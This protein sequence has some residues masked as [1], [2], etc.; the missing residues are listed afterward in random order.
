[1]S[2]LLCNH[3]QGICV[4]DRPIRPGPTTI[5]ELET[6]KMIAFLL[7]NDITRASLIKTTGLSSNAIDIILA[8]FGC[9]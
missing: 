9:Q 3:N 5:S 4:Y 1:M 6:I 7:D 2:T 8:Y